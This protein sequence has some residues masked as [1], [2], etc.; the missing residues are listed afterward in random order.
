MEVSGQI[1]V[2]ATWLPGKSPPGAHWI[3]GGVS[4]KT[5]LDAVSSH[6]A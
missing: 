1:H 2:P 5:C 3:G 6:E 4:P